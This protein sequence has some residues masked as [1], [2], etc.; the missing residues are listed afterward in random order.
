MGEGL[1]RERFN[2]SDIERKKKRTNLQKRRE[3]KNPV[4]V[5]R[6]KTVSPV[7]FAFG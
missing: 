3:K 4:V 7:W 5:I 2:D 1:A 6:L